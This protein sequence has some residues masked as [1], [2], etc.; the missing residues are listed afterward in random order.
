VKIQI[1]KRGYRCLVDTGAEVSIMHEKVFKELKG[2]ELKQKEVAL[3]SATGSA[4]L[5]KGVT[6]LEFK[7]GQ[8]TFKHR[9]VVV[10]NLNRNFI[11]GN[12]WLEINGAILYFNLMKLRVG[13]QYVPLEEDIHISSLVRAKKDYVL[14]PQT[15]AIVSVK[16]KNSDYFKEEENFEISPPKVGFVANETGL[17]VYECGVKR[18][19]RGQYP[20]LLANGTNKT[21][22]IKRGCVLGVV[23]P[24]MKVSS[25]SFGGL[26]AAQKEEEE[27]VSDEQ[28]HA[29]KER[30]S[31]VVQLV[32]NHP[33]LFASSDLDLT[34]TKTV[35][36]TVDTADSPPVRQKPYKTPLNKRKVIDKAIDEMLEAKVIERSK[37]PWSFPVVVVDKSDGTKRFCVDFRKLNS[38]TKP[39]SYPLPLIDDILAQLGEAKFFTCLDLKSGYWQVKMDENDKEKTA[40]ACHRGLFQFLVMPF[41]LCN[42]PSVFML[43]MNIVLQ[44]LEDFACAYLDDV[45]IFSRT[46]EEHRKHIEL[47]FQRLR[48]HNLKL[49]LKKCKFYQSETEYLGFLIG[50]DGVKPN[51]NKV[52]AIKGMPAPKTVREVRSFIGMCSYYRRF[53]PSFSQI[54]EPLIALTRKYARFSWSEE[55]QKAFDLIKERLTVA[56]L[57]AY[58]DTTKPYVLYT[59]ASDSCIGAC[60]AQVVEEDGR[61]EEKPIYFLS[62]RLSDTQ[63]RWPTIEKEA[64]A[65]HFAL[66]KLDHYLHNA[67]FVIRTDHKP[68]KY[69][70]GSPMKNK[71]IQMWALNLSSYNC[72]I[73]YIPGPQNVLADL[74]S[75]M[76]E[77]PEK[78]KTSTTKEEEVNDLNDN[79]LEVNA[80]NSNRFDPKKFASYRPPAEAVEKTQEISIARFDLKKEQE[81]DPELKS[82]RDRV[83]EGKAKGAEAKRHILVNDVLYFLSYPDDRPA[84]RLYVPQ[85]LKQPLL[86]QYHDGNGHMGTD[87]TYDTMGV[88]YYWPGMY[89]DIYGYI[90]GCTACQARNLKAKKPPITETD[91]PPYPFAKVSMDISGPYPR[92]LSGNKYILSIVDHYSGWPEAFPLPDKSAENVAHVVIDEVVPRFGCP[93]QV[94]TDN[95]TE[96]ENKVMRETLKTL[97]IDHVTTSFYHP[98]ANAKVERFHR[99]LHDILAKK[100]KDDLSTWDMY[101][102]QAL[103]AVRTS[104]SESTG[105]SPYY[106]LYSRDPVLPIDNVL[107]PRRKYMGEEAHK[108]ALQEQHKAFAVVQNKLKKEKK[109]QK[110]YANKNRK[111]VELQVGDPVYLKKHQRKSKLE[112]KWTPYYRVVE[113]LSPLTYLIRSQLDGSTTKSHIKHLRLAAIG[114]WEIPKDNLERPI[115]KAAFVVPPSSSE[116]DSSDDNDESQTDD[117]KDDEP[118]ARRVRRFRQERSDSSE[119]DI[120]LAELRRRFRARE[121]RIRKH[122]DGSS[123]DVEDRT[124][125]INSVRKEMKE[126]MSGMLCAIQKLL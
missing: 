61:Q 91:S 57:L 22:K 113:K 48:E 59:D 28:I 94:V 74:L 62:H 90:Q 118:L 12:D 52:E 79:T 3:Q 56:P 45:I 82:I 87:K 109:R 112:N 44:G 103:S 30:K 101:L 29:P 121:C 4:L 73:D 116:S 21:Y 85:Q 46:A 31:E 17:K 43:L 100:L 96:N 55:C 34:Q 111:L 63:R 67:E 93:L 92:S 105:F 122:E 33:D 8:K 77:D 23:E 86:K 11:L 107:K 89:Q 2:V 126:A 65:I 53:V 6:D 68:L 40:F 13:D 110:E 5:V 10:S 64:Y 71:K 80:I 123:D 99:T 18:N 9:F 84:T 97:N 35:T 104:V 66:Q 27:E 81:D 49:K 20:L 58:P 50:A 36:C 98:E 38:V 95:G 106:L 125:E 102:N 41:G 75:R 1:G 19:K 7:L 25:V 16:M 60:L 42:A 124:G 26:S 88:K 119:D 70:L 54:A 83:R 24:V 14:S 47:V 32:R 117:A 69:L 37:S 76:P 72:T 114:D 120:P 51:P 108:I 39:M 78:E 15:A 115:R